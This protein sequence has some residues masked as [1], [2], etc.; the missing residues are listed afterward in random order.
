ML[1]VLVHVADPPAT[2]LGA[3]VEILTGGL[4]FEGPAT[5]GEGGRVGDLAVG[6]EEAGVDGLER[7]AAFLAM[8]PIARWRLTMARVWCHIHVHT[9]PLAEPTATRLLVNESS[10]NR[11]TPATCE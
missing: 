11:L 9:T 3:G 8:I 1:A 5:G 6:G 4:P 2:L 7:L 10:A